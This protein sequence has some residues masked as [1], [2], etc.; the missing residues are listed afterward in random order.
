ML[1]G[2]VLDVP[3]LSSSAQTLYQRLLGVSAVA[4][5][6]DNG[7][8]AAAISEL[9]EAGLA[10]VRPHDADFGTPSENVRLVATPPDDAL[11]GLLIVAEKRLN[12][13]QE[14]LHEVR[15]GLARLRTTFDE[16]RGHARP[17]GL[18]EI[19]VGRE[20]VN[21]AHRTVHQAAARQLSICDTGHFDVPVATTTVIV[22][23]AAKV[24]SG[25]V[26]RAVYDR[27][28]FSIDP[29]AGAITLSE[30]LAGGE[31]QRMV[32]ELP[33]KFVLADESLALVALTRTGTDSALLVRSEP[34]LA[35]LRMYFEMLWERA[36]P[37]GG[38]PDAA[39]D[40][41]KYGAL[42]R[43]LAS[44]LSDEAVAGQLGASVRTVRRRVA[45]LMEDLGAVTRFQAGVLAQR[46]GLLPIAI[47]LPAALELPT[48]L[49]LTD[50]VYDLV[51]ADIDLRESACSDRLV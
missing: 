25:V 39:Q 51:A 49:D 27:S 45:Q 26:F 47:D 24:S 34:F 16:G 20:V 40:H 18:C 23:E 5:A 41:K 30:S 10:V 7:L 44:G 2:V 14:E 31:I 36:V 37:L 46:A 42:P 50:A 33:L 1:G 8:P 38:E 21:A 3:G 32:Q 43:L 6:A 15:R 29:V 35:L 17:A 22:P 9:V 4:I 48:A 12:E 19:L 13:R 11:A 28:I